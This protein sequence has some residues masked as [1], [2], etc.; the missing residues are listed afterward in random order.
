MPKTEVVIIGAGLSGLTCARRLQESKVGFVILD[1]SDAIGGRV[2]TDCVEGFMLDRGFQ[3]FLDAYP[4]PR[5]WVDLDD[6]K[7][8][9]FFPGAQV[10]YGDRFHRMADPFRRPVEAME[11]LFNPIGGILDKL[12]VALVRSKACRG[13]LQDLFARP[14]QT[15]LEEL[16]QAGFSQAMIDRFFRPFLSGILLD[17]EL[18]TSSRIFEFLFRMFST[19]NSALPAGGMGELPK[20]L[21]GGLP[22][23]CIQ[24]NSIVAG[25]DDNRVRLDS[26]E[27]WDAR[28]V[29]VATDGSVAAKLTGL[30]PQVGS[31]SVQCH[32]Y[33]GPAS[34]N[35][36]PILFLDG[37]GRKPFNTAVFINAIQPQSAPAG[38]GLLSVTALGANPVNESIAREQ[39][40]DWF[41]G[42]VANW[43][44][45][46]KY[47]ITHAQP[48]LSQ[49]KL[50]GKIPDARVRKGLY[51]CGDYRWTAS[52]NGA[53]ES[54]RLAAETVLN[55]I[56]AAVI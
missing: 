23:R 13:T 29:V 46:R 10:W 50:P 54:G 30:I 5:R 36:E 25:I 20:Q 39:L 22:A 11:S 52:I 37:T 31:R 40:G 42:E 14:E 4:E 38:M 12:K 2:R 21:A 56:A 16:V 1:A 15:T 3:I 26:G 6:L 8:R 55:D 7:L 48:D 17:R 49:L 35:Q 34:Q 33:V 44:L 45:L 41:G 9:P 27:I 51:A 28:A 18:V 19:G 53:M 24:L 32:Y 47:L 43:R